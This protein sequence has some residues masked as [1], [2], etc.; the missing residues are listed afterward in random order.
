M[1]EIRNERWMAKGSGKAA[2]SRR[3]IKTTTRSRQDKDALSKSVHNGGRLF[4]VINNVTMAYYREL[5][6][7]CE[8]VR[9]PLAYECG[10]TTGG[11]GRAV[12]A[13]KQNIETDN[14]H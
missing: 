13:N 12:Y 10:A 8:T 4:W 6:P 9:G 3:Y 7:A 14:I 5:W 2:Q 11:R 1:S